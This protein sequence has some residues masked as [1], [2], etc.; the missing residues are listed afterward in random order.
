MGLFDAH[1]FALVSCFELLPSLGLEL[2]FE[3]R[4]TFFG[5]IRFD[6][7]SVLFAIYLMI[8]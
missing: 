2:D 5:H 7:F 8:L 1:F 3:L 4:D 6:V